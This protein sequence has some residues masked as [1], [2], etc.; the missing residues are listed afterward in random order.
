MIALPLSVLLIIYAAIVLAS[1]ILWC[2]NVYHIISSASMTPVAFFFSV[3][4]A[5][6]GL[7]VIGVTWLMLGDVSWSGKIPLF[8]AADFTS[9]A[10]PL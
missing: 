4:I 1:I 7:V 3:S 8:D 10:L 9:E 5:F 2:I 6:L